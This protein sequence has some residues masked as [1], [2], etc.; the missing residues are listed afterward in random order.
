MFK[1]KS[2]YSLALFLLLSSA[3]IARQQNTISGTIK[4]INGNAVH[5]A[6]ILIS[7]SKR[8]TITDL[9]GT[10][11]L[12]A[13]PS[14][15]LIISAV[16]FTTTGLSIGDATVLE[17]RLAYNVR[18]L[19]EIVVIGYGTQNRKDLTGAISS[20]HQET[21][22]KGVITSPEQL[23][24]G[25][26][27]GVLVTQN[28]GEPG[29]AVN[30]RIRGNN[31]VRA[32]NSP[33]FVVDGYPIDNSSST[34]FA[35][36]LYE[37]RN[38]LNFLNPID[39]ES[40]DVLKD[41]SAT[42]IYGSRGANGVV[43]ITTKRGT[44]AFRASTSSYIGISHLRK[45]LSVL[46]AEDYR[47]VQRGREGPKENGW[48]HD[49]GNNTDW[50]DEIY[51]T[52]LTQNYDLSLSGGN[53][54]TTFRFSANA[55]DQDGIILGSNFTRYSSRLTVD[56][57]ALNDRLRLSI[58]MDYTQT[59]DDINGSDLVFR[60]I[61]TNP[62]RP[63]RNEDGS[64]ISTPDFTSPLAF[65]DYNADET[66][67]NR[68]LSNLTAAYDVSNSFTYKVNFGV[69][70]TT[71]RRKFS[72]SPALI[73]FN[74]GLAQISNRL[75]SS[76]LIEQFITYNSDWNNIH[77]LTA[78]AGYSYQKFNIEHFFLTRTGF[79][80]DFIPLVND[81]G[82]GTNDAGS[83][84]GQESSALQ[85]FFGRANYDYANKL[86]VTATVRTDGSTRF[87][88]DNRYGVFPS[89]GVAFKLHETGL[90]D[91]R[92]WID[93]LKLRASWGITGN[94]EIPN[95]ISQQLF[96]TSP[97][98]SAILDGLNITTGFTTLR[99]ANPEL[100]WEQTRQ[101][102]VGLD[103]NFF[104]GKISGSLDYFDKSTNDLLFEIP[105]PSA[106]TTLGFRNL[107]ARVINRGFE[108]GLASSVISNKDFGWTIAGNFTTLHN[109]V[110]DLLL[111]QVL[112][113]TPAGV[114]SGVRN[115]IIT[116]GEQIAVYYGKVWL[117]FNEEGISQFKQERVGDAMVDVLE[118]IGTPLPTL[119]YGI[120]NRLSY[121]GFNLSF[122]F[123]GVQGNDLF[124]NKDNSI[125]SKQS[126][127]SGGNTS[128]DKIDNGESYDNPVQFSSRF[129]ENGSFLRLNFVSLSYDF[130]VINISWLNGLSLYA[131]VNNPWIL[132]NYKGYDPEIYGSGSSSTD[133][134]GR[135]TGI[136]SLG[137][138][139]STTPKP[140]SYL[141]GVTV[142]F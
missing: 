28:S 87:G 141:M 93:Q 3:T 6:S 101:V 98:A 95:K 86:L 11:S 21:F 136:P 72:E 94:Q 85:S 26:M 47:E 99:T 52:A 64:P 73:S 70:H 133:E 1:S 92:R 134:F 117:G 105:L 96:A 37:E 75:L 80:S 142:D 125:L 61:G 17:L 82:A 107:D 115:Q 97:Q 77:Q 30:I 8:G 109:E 103:F 22:N 49:F 18:T 102:D 15:S 66:L 124:N 88:D 5:G 138:D 9:N 23:I 7:G 135:S 53:E 67:T 116:N 131:T 126:I 78:M 108:V 35:G 32:G 130:N 114:G 31:T 40:I 120:T 16:G 25:K 42:A 19:E 74:N 13:R 89:L 119:V 59:Q 34:P 90:L 41:A 128:S 2:F 55:M 60:G 63:S 10:F 71:A 122:L 111:D 140:I 121:K 112:F 58:N 113:G 12:D 14:D 106:P 137:N 79:Q 29:G 123:N 39:I 118:V 4:D 76:Y 84:S 50:Q 44:D 83:A 33:L 62:T 91:G 24:Q 36:R 104:N 27:A 132:T 43:I 54:E 68:F 81:I 129:I 48:P 110:Q 45:K 46:S 56:Q 57:K 65:L 69:D 100:K 38:P 51:H 139:F 20:A 127:K